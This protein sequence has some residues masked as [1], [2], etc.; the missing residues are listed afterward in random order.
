MAKK[1]TKNKAGGVKALMAARLAR[2]GAAPKGSAKTPPAAHPGFAAVA[3]KIQGQGH[4]P[5][6]SKAILAAAST[7]LKPMRDWM[8]LRNNVLINGKPAPAFA[9]KYVVQTVYQENESG[10]WYNW[11]IVLG[12]WVNQEEYD[13]AKKFAQLMA[14]GEFQIGR[15]PEPTTED[16]KDDVPV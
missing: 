13:R 16:S 5:E 15:P 14:S 9:R 11:K 10:S 12:D 7:G 1:K 3:K 6:A 4:S 2:K 8:T